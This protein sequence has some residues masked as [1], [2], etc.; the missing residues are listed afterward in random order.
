MA[1][2]ELEKSGLGL[3]HLYLHSLDPTIQAI[4]DVVVSVVEPLPVWMGLNL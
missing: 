4:V 3:R 1:K 2:L